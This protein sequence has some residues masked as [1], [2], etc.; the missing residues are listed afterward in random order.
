MNLVMTIAK[1]LNRSARVLTAGLIFASIFV[2]SEQ[3]AFAATRCKDRKACS[4]S[5][6]HSKVT[7]SWVFNVAGFHGKSKNGP[8]APKRIH[9]V[10]SNGKTAIA[11]RH[12]SP[13]GGYYGRKR[14][15]AHYIYRPRSSAKPTRIVVYSRGWR[16]SISV[17][18]GPKLSKPRGGGNPKCTGSSSYSGNYPPSTYAGVE[19]SNKQA[20]EYG[21]RAGFRTEKQLVTVVEI[22]VAESGLVTRTRR[23]HPE[24]GF[25]SAGAKL[26]VG[27]PCSAWYG[28]RQMHSDRGVWQISSHF[29]GQYSDAQ[30]DD[31]ASAA[32][33]MWTLSHHG[34]DFTPWNTYTDG[35]GNADADVV[36]AVREVIASHR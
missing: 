15:N 8:K 6:A 17:F 13:Y 16:G 18:S 34:T 23:W 5:L 4:V 31:P 20:A 24:F 36:Q 32:R 3:S 9:V 10:L 25:R 12:A 33:I 7:K 14:V 2:V 21:W 28:N 27:G 29:W 26:G 1:L 30:T 35:L 11:K 19:L 22:G